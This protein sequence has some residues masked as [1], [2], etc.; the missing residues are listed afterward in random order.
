MI[1]IRIKTYVVA[2][3]A[4]A[5]LVTACSDSTSPISQAT[6]ASAL[7]QRT[8]SSNPTPA[9]AP[10]PASGCEAITGFV[11]QTGSAFRAA[12]LIQAKASVTSTCATA[13]Y[14]SVEFKNVQ[15][16]EVESVSD[17]WVGAGFKYSLNLDGGLLS[18]TTYLLT[19]TTFMSPD[20]RAAVMDSRTLTITTP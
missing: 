5:L 13:A 10:T 4:L 9:P 19:L 7:L 14:F 17:G 2:A 8:S 6:P 18:G 12:G 15:T 1:S 11:A 16:G 20:T 3:A